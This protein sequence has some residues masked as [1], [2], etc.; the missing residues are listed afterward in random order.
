VLVVED[1]PPAAE[2]VVRH[3]ARGGFRAEVARTGT[4]AV[5]LARELR[6]VAITLDILLPELD[7]WGV[8]NQL[9]QEE[10]TRD[11]PVVVV[12]VVD[13][14]DLGLALGAIDYFVKPVSAK[15][16]LNRLNRYRFGRRF[17]REEVR[18]LVVDDEEANRRWLTEILEPAGFTVIAAKGGRD[19][20]ELAHSGRPDLVLLDLM[21]PEITG[22]DVVSALRATEATASIPI[23]ILTAKN[24]SESD[25]RQL[26]GRVAAILSRGS[27]G[28]AELLGWLDQIVTESTVL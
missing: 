14:P 19:A 10:S 4:E 24:L 1:H 28:S 2:L 6:P 15:E 8:L 21:M 17:G 3:L 9:K 5:A 25:K 18:V 22:F 23:M 26:N 12:S 7:G 27:T 13:N 20:I 16:L 11:I